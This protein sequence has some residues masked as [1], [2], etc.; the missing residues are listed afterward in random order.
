MKIIANGSVPSH[1]PHGFTAAG[2]NNELS[3]GGKSFIA[4]MYH[5]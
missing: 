1:F 2:W 5:W 4:R 3:D